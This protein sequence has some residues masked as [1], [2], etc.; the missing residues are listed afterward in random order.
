MIKKCLLFLL[1]FVTL[2]LASGVFALAEGEADTL[3]GEYLEIMPE[4][5]A[6]PDELI[7]LLGPDALL[8]EL[9]SGLTRE[10]SRI[11]S[12]FLLLI[13]L[14]VLIAI[15]GNVSGELAPLIRASA[16]SVAALAIFERLLPLIS[17]IA[18]TFSVLSGFFSSVAPI[19]ISAVAMG[20]GASTS[21]TASLG[22]GITLAI[23]E[24]FSRELLMTLA[25]AMFFSG[26]AGSFGG[27]LRTVS[28]GIRSAFTKGMGLVS[29]VL[30]GL[31]SLQTLISAAADNMALRAARY[32]SVSTLPIVGSTVAGAL[33]SLVGGLAYA[34]S[35][36]GGSAIL[37]I[38]TTAITPLAMLLLY[39]L[40]FFL[41]ITFLEFSASDEGVACLSAIRDAL[42]ALIAVY[43]VTAVV[44]ILELSLLL[45][46]EVVF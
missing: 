11:V 44:Y 46:V 25:V 3:I 36:I 23:T 21:G 39:K 32:A 42:D 20:G 8:R 16:S 29:T 24:L 43:V 41:A 4:G 14:S 35:V 18:E 31:L 6:D 28:R 13:G 17:E 5:T 10:R 37:V 12:F 27:G 45:R 30:L 22:V 1:L 26:L 34:K 38:A 2:F 15:S 33:S 7:S 19:L 9:L 40:C